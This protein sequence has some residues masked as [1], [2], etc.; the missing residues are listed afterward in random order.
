MQN[1]QNQLVTIVQDMHKKVNE[2]YIDWKAAG[3]GGHTE[4]DTKWIEVSM[5]IMFLFT[6][7]RYYS[8]YYITDRIQST[9]QFLTY[10]RK[11]NIQAKNIL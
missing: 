9:K 4:N 5:N 10:L 6:S 8:K 3:F 11:S 7:Y 2:M 1:V